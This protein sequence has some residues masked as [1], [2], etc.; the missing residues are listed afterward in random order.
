MRFWGRTLRG[1][2]LLVLVG[3]TTV[4]LLAMGFTSVVLL[5]QSLVAR[6]DDKLQAMARP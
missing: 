1:R 3:A 4:G 5:D 2:L 6:V